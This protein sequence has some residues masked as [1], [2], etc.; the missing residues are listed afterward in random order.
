MP[1]KSYSLIVVPDDHSGT[2]QYWLSW[3]LLLFGMIVSVLFLATVLYFMFTYAMVWREAQRVRPLQSENATLRDQLVV[4]NELNDELEDLSAMRAQ[5]LNMLGHGLDADALEI[6]DLY[7]SEMDFALLA[8]Q[9]DR[10]DHLRAA[11]IFRSF[12]PSEWPLN[13]PVRKEFYLATDDDPLG[14]PGL[15]IQP[16]D[17]EE[18]VHAAG[19]GRVIQSGFDEEL[20]VF[21][22]LDHGL[23]VE[24]VYGNLRDVRVTVGQMVDRKQ[25]LAYLGNSR[26]RRGGN[27]YFEIRVDGQAVDPRQHLRK[28]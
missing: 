28:R 18:E 27:L 17:E 20:G 2:K 19:S 9:A 13:G 15:D 12:S 24:S 21:V 14:H 23:T 4:L 5:I 26:Q 10:L 7:D 8:L 16:A 25:P 11:A 22:R 1:T 3:R 6:E